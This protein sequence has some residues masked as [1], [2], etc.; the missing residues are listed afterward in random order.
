LLAI[1]FFFFYLLGFPPQ[2]WLLLSEMFNWSQSEHLI[3]YH[4]PKGIIHSQKFDVELNFHAW[5]KKGHVVY[6]YKQKTPVCK[7]KPEACDELFQPSWELIQK[8][9]GQLQ[10][11]ENHWDGTQTQ[12]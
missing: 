4:G 1:T 5:F 9:L 8:G 3:C 6:I 11:K 10:V 7:R 12:S 2:L